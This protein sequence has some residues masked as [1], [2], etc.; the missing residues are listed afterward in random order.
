M[1]AETGNRALM[2]KLEALQKQEDEIL[3]E[4]ELARIDE[5]RIP[6]VPQIESWLTELA[7]LDICDPKARYHLINI[8][9][10]RVYLYDDRMILFF[11]MGNKNKTVSLKDIREIEKNS[12]V[13]ND[14]DLFNSCVTSL[15]LS[16]SRRYAIC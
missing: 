3:D 14:F 9:V 16:K 6:T 13:L 1:I 8:F 5:R 4:L 15:I 10:N 7:G 11:N 2:A 12:E